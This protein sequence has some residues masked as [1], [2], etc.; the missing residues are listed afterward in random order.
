MNLNIPTTPKFYIFSLDLYYV[1]KICTSNSFLIN[2]LWISQRYLQLH[3]P[4]NNSNI[5][6]KPVSPTVFPISVNDNSI[7]LAAH[8]KILS[9]LS[10]PPTCGFTPVAVTGSA[11]MAGRAHTAGPPSTWY[12]V[13]GIFSSWPLQDSLQGKPQHTST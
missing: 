13:S 11:G 8:G 5:P 7:L 3:L 10:N 2:F 4:Q 9:P 1:L 12:S 6:P